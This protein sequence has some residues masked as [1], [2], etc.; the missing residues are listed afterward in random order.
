VNSSSLRIL[1]AL[2]VKRSYYL[3]TYDVKTAFLYGELDEDIY[4]FSPK[5]FNCGN[6]IYM[7][8]TKIS[9]WIKTSSVKMESK[10]FNISQG[11]GFR[12]I[13]N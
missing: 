9:V 10:I 12:A 6:K 4:M 2:A 3:F 5:G 8:V 1:F 13:E 11:K 7:Q